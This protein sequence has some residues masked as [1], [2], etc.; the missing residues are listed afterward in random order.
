MEKLLVFR[1]ILESWTE[2]CKKELT[3]KYSEANIG[4]YERVS[5][6]LKVSP[7]RF[8]LVNMRNHYS[9]ESLLTDFECD[10]VSNEGDG[11]VM[12]VIICAFANDGYTA[13]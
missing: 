9:A 12:P 5:A 11:G 8:A 7:L 6:T 3:E 1:T 4:K 2:T 10:L 13:A